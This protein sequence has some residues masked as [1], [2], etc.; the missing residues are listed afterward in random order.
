MDNGS[1]YVPMTEAFK[2]KTT[3]WTYTA[4]NSMDYETIAAKGIVMWCEKNISGRWT[5]LGGSKFGF[6]DSDDALL[7]KLQFEGA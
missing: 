2:D 3:D 1:N 7:F 5:M 4:I 6:E